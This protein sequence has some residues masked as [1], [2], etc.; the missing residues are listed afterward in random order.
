MAKIVLIGPQFS[1]KSS[2]VDV[3][4]DRAFEYHYT[5]TI[6][7][8]VYQLGIYL[9][10]DCSGAEMY[11]MYIANCLQD[12]DKVFLIF[13]GSTSCSNQEISRW[14]KIYRTN[15]PNIPLR[16]VINKTD[17]QQKLDLPSWLTEGNEV[18]HMSVKSRDIF[19]IP[20]PIQ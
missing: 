3:L 13:D 6:G 19:N 9:L 5:S 12:A 4:F 10:Y 8:A 16:I 11:E 15:C 2:L 1:G 18:Y 17:L 14:Y 20:L 7:Y